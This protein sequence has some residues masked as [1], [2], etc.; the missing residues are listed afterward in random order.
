MKIKCLI[1]QNM[2]NYGNKVFNYENRL[3]YGKYKV[4]HY[5]NKTREW[6]HDILSAYIYV[7]DF[8]S[9]FAYV[10]NSHSRT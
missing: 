4:F 2:I 3:L 5:E 10:F 7:S 6:Y 8:F 9:F 1:T